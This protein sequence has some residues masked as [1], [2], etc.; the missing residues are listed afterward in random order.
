V[1]MRPPPTGHPRLPGIRHL[2]CCATNPG[3]HLVTVSPDHEF[4]GP[5]A[6]SCALVR[7]TA[8]RGG[9]HPVTLSS[10]HLHTPTLEVKRPG[11]RV[12]GHC[13]W[14]SRWNN[15]TAEVPDS[16]PPVNAAAPFEGRIP[17]PQARR[18]GRTLGRLRVQRRP[19]SRG[20]GGAGDPSTPLNGTRAGCVMRRGILRKMLDFVENAC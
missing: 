3:R 8:L 7:C 12:P 13:L 14:P 9:R 10:D 11:D 6:L 16:S 2:P 15:A 20:P 19:A 18:R 5:G 1:C 4:R 17:T